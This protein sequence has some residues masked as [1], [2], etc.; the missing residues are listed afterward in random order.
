MQTGRYSVNDI[1]KLENQNPIGPEGDKR[2]VP[3]NL[4]PLDRIDE[5]IDAAMAP[6]VAP[7]PEP[8]VDEESG[9]KPAARSGEMR[10]PAGTVDARVRLAGHHVLLFTDVMTR[11]VEQEVK[12]NRRAVKQ[13]LATSESASLSEWLV[14]FYEKFPG[15]VTRA[16]LPAVVAYMEATA[17]LICA[18]FGSDVPPDSLA[19]FMQDYARD[20][21]L[22]H[23]GRSLN[24]LNALV[25]DT[26][27]SKLKTAI[28]ERLDDWSAQRGPWAGRLELNQAG[29][30]AAF[31]TFTLLGVRRKRW[32]ARETMDLPCNA[33]NGR[34]VGVNDP[35]ARK[36]EVLGEYQVQRDRLHPP[37]Q[38]GCICMIEAEV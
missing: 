1:L 11:V 13:H 35:I 16:L 2:F 20:A 12:A 24:Q 10:R 17:G 9:V 37:L 36:G 3:M 15:D 32:I 4:V 14:G 38:D 22:R 5:Q 8:T 23:A 7:E 18:S 34:I 31:K 33:L 19:T 26:S 29:N 6:P 28:N 21:G 25:R 27:P 30:A